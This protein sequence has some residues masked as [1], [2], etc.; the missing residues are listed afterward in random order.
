MV[1]NILNSTQPQQA[2]TAAVH[3]TARPNATLVMSSTQ[4]LGNTAAGAGGGVFAT[5]PFDVFLQC[6]DTRI[7]SG[8]QTSL[9]NIYCCCPHC[10]ILPPPPSDI[11]AITICKTMCTCCKGQSDFQSTFGTS[12]TSAASVHQASVAYLAGHSTLPCPCPKFQQLLKARQV[13]CHCTRIS[14]LFSA[15]LCQQLPWQNHGKLRIT[16]HPHF[17]LALWWTLPA[18]MSLGN[19]HMHGCA[20]W[21]P[22]H[23]A[24]TAMC[25]GAPDVA[26]DALNNSMAQGTVTCPSWQSESSCQSAYGP[27]FAFPASKLHAAC[28]NT[29]QSM[30]HTCTTSEDGRPAVSNFWS[31]NTLDSATGQPV[32][33]LMLDIS[34]Q[35]TL[36]QSV[37]AGLEV[38]NFHAPYNDSICNDYV[39]A[40]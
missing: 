22:N 27:L 11:P 25:T 23:Q 30:T 6:G 13:D 15:L 33:K 24:W 26:L 36:G 39:H 7:S 16:A 17:G 31:T 5:S 10:C 35:D 38:T 12:S 18:Q 37:T 4:L 9:C 29:T 19:A 8:G 21:G 32:A 1:P 34:L 14:L 2:S 3:A 28:P 20:S 40:Q